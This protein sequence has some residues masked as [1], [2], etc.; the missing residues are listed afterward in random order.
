MDAPERMFE[1]RARGVFLVCGLLAMAAFPA[2]S[3]R[4][5]ACP[6]PASA[7][8]EDGRTIAV[9]C[10]RPAGPAIEGPARLL[11]GRGLDPNTADEATLAALPGIGT[12][13]AAQIARVRRERRF[14]RVEDLARVPGIGPATVERLRPWLE[15]PAG[16]GGAAQVDPA[17]HGK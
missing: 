9:R 6:A 17:T 14:E 2:R 13:R 1:R 16:T 10:E 4:R 5:L 15:L 7:A 11:F 3:P 12:A 8:V